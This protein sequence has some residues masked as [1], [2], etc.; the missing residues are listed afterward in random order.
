MSSLL[1][2][3]SEYAVRE[4]D[5]APSRLWNCSITELLVPLDSP[6]AAG[7]QASHHLEDVQALEEAR[8]ARDATPEVLAR[9]QQE[10]D[11]AYKER[12]RNSGIVIARW[13]DVKHL[14][15]EEPLG[16]AKTK[17]SA[18][19]KATK[20]GVSKAANADEVSA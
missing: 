1:G 9:A 12:A 13:A 20:T 8:A 14:E 16:A 19:A 2:C 4:E 3:I 15:E 6:L 11:E 10:R 18:E 17:G 5:V 7:V